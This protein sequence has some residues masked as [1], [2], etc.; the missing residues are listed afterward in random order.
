M[1]TDSEMKR[2]N[3]VTWSNTKKKGTKLSKEKGQC[4]W[5]SEWMHKDKYGA[6]K[7]R[8]SD[9]QR[10]TKHESNKMSTVTMWGLDQMNARRDG[11]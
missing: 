2:D 3:N 6:R 1:G 7:S 9:A 4:K 5:K 8:E 11:N 10:W